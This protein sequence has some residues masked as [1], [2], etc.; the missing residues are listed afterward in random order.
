MSEMS[1]PVRPLPVVQSWDCHQSGSCCKEYR[2][3]LSEDE[4]RRIEE[5]GWTA[6]ELG[7]DPPVVEAGWWWRREK[8]L[9]SRGAEGCVFLSESGRCRIHE[10]FGYEAK[11]LPCRLFPFAL[12][13][14]GGHWRVGVRFACPSAAANLGRQVTEYSGE[15]QAWA[16]ELTA[17]EGLSA[18]P[19]G[20]LAPPPLLDDG[21]R[22]SWPD[23]LA[24]ADAAFKILRDPRSPVERRVRKLLHLAGSMKQARLEGVTGPRLVELLELLSGAAEAEVPARPEQVEAPTWLGRVL[25]R[26][27]AAVYTRKDQGPRRGAPLR[28]VLGRLGAAWSFLWGRGP[29]PR[30][31]QVIPEATFE[32]AEAPRGPL[33]REAE[34][35]LERYFAVKV[36]SLQFC[37]SRKGPPF[38]E[39]LESLLLICPLALWL[40]RLF[41]DVPREKAVVTALTVLDDHFG[42]NPVLYSLRQRMGLRILAW[43]GD[44]ARLT[45]WYSR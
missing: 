40:S 43:R 38:W 7:G 21:T 39:G 31:H 4:A 19:D 45:A 44:L 42:Y 28:S 25:F 26:Q 3:V 2:I 27:A 35:V 23:T 9:G 30:L 32:E 11:P 12:Y 33:P 36:W 20:S 22:L 8:R 15:L 1:L 14:A 5:Q 17:R 37:S 16:Q 34:A 18:R 13:P 10:K 41:R 6:E 29:V 24:L